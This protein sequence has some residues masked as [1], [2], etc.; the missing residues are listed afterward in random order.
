MKKVLGL[1]LCLGLIIF[2]TGVIANADTIFSDNFNRSPSNTVGNGWGEIQDYYDDVAIINYDSNHLGVLMLR[3]Q[4][5]GSYDAAAYHDVDLTGYSNI[6]LSFDYL[7]F[8]STE[9]TDKILVIWR[10]DGGSWNQVTSYTLGGS[11]WQSVANLSL[12]SG[13]NGLSAFRFGFATSVSQDDEGVYIDNV[14]LSGKV[15]EPTSLLF[16]GSGLLGLVL[17]RRKKL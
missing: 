7:A 11:G 14:V 12:G 10:N 16:L 8:S 2:G 17:F 13:V 4:S 1:L 6:T 5:S 9:N 15:P 3:D